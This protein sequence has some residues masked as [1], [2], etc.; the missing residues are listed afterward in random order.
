[1]LEYSKIKERKISARD[2]LQQRKN[3]FYTL[4][5]EMQ[6]GDRDCYFKYV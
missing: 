6:F 3:L 1:M 2:I 5:Q 4:V